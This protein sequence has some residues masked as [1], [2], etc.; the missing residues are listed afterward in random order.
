MFYQ[1]MYKIVEFRINPRI[2]IDLDSGKTISFKNKHLDSNL[3]NKIIKDFLSNKAKK[4]LYE[5][6]FNTGS[7]DNDD[8]SQ[9]L[10][11][12]LVSIK[13]N[14][15][16]DNFIILLHIYLSKSIPKQYSSLNK[17]ELL[18]EKDI[19]KLVSKKNIIKMIKDNINHIYRSSGHF[20]DYKLD[21]IDVYV[22]ISLNSGTD[23]Y[24]MNHFIIK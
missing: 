9:Y 8:L 24:V 15:P 10:D 11:G 13:Y 17:N 7:N 14:K 16:T 6:I 12:K 19:I 2:I 21:G 18:P 3:K 5:N 1:Y 4:H 22:D 23:K 20:K